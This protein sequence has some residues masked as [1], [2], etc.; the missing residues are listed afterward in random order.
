MRRNTKSLLTLLFFTS[1]L[2]L[3]CKQEEKKHSEHKFTNALIDETSP[4]LLQHAHN[5]VDWRPWSQAALDEAQKENKLVLVSIGYS[6]CHWC[7]VMEDETFED[8]EVAKMMNKDFINI[9]V[10][11]EERPDV[12][13]VYMTAIQLIKGD[14]GWPLNVITLPNGKPIYG[15]TYHTK[16]QWQK[17]LTEISGLYAKDPEKANRYA[18]MVA[19]GVQEV[20]LIQPN[21][22]DKLLTQDALTTSVEKWKT[23]WDLEWGGNQGYQKFML[24]N[25]LDFLLDYAE[26]TGDSQVREH[27][28]NTLDKMAMGGVYDHI[29]GGFFR[30]SIDVEWK[31]PHFEKMLY[32]NAQL[33][34]LYS[35]AYTIFGNPRYK[36]I[37]LQ[38]VAFLDREMKNP[39]G[40]YYAAMD[41]DSEGEEGK[42]YVWQETALKE[43]LKDDFQLFSAYYNISPENI[44]EHDN[45]VL[46]TSN[47][48]EAFSETN[49]LSQTD[50]ND[51][52]KT[53][54]RQLLTLRQ[55]RVAPRIDDKIITSWNAL[56]ID[57]FVDAYKAFGNEAFLERATSI[58]DFMSEKNLEGNQLI[59][60]YKK[61]GRRVDGFLEDYAFLI[62]ASLQLYSATLDAKYLSL[63]NDLNEV[64][65][66][67]FTDARSGMF[68]FSKS[69]ELISNIIKTDDGV[70]PSPNGVM[71]HNLLRLGHIYYDLEA[72]EQSKKMLSALMPA[73]EEYA[74]NY[75]N[76]NA[77]LLNTVYPFY[78]VA[79]VGDGAKKQL[80]EL[81]ALH[82]PNVLLVG[83]TAASDLPLFK[84]RY[85]DG[86]TYIYVCKNTTC[87]LPVT[88]TEAAIEQLKNF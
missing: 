87:K 26:I 85:V 28:R 51:K 17:V 54:K 80:K 71:A 52:K 24:P 77:L 55:N 39:E 7:H 65:K 70:I 58:F 59:H 3:S 45:Y 14:A 64:V 18:D 62:D 43:A 27:V 5:P 15:G 46:H 79:V 37:V 68:R 33:I 50:L 23:H 66:T 56:L 75:S 29:G 8:E 40:G 4:Y 31:V 22:D 21:T 35:K 72:Q 83:S 38:T 6:S 9:K 42:Y 2:F 76:W 73:M 61:G 20:N 84:N 12:D 63:A 53:W 16:E 47:K 67:D 41:A 48:D 19:R 13:Q 78:E 1:L 82:L 86:D 11:R 60:S 49:A 25:D 69:T 44:W 74:I 81:A 32:D 10:D 34:G 88:T 36:E 57:G 30:Y